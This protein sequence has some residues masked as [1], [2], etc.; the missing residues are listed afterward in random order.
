LRGALS[1]T[2][3]PINVYPRVPTTVDFLKSGQHDNK[4]EGSIPWPFRLD[5]ALDDKA[6]YGFTIEV[7]GDDI[8][9]NIRVEID[10]AGKWDAITG[11]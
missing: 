11:R 2:P 7:I 6:T 8:A 4:L 9:Q 10:W 5:G 3:S 1:L